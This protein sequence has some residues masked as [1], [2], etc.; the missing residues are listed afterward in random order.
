VRGTYTISTNTWDFGE[1]PDYSYKCSALYIPQTK[2]VLVVYG[3]DATN[4]MYD[5]V[6]D[7]YNT[8][9]TNLPNPGNT[10]AAGAVFYQD[11][12]WFAGAARDLQAFRSVS[13]DLSTWTNRTSNANGTAY[14]DLIQIDNVMITFGGIESDDELSEGV[15]RINL[16]NIT[17]EEWRTLDVELPMALGGATAQLVGPHIYLFGGVYHNETGYA[18]FNAKSWIVPCVNPAA[19]DQG[20]DV[21]TRQCMSPPV[22]PTEPVAPTNSPISAPKSATSNAAVKASF[23]GLVLAGICIAL[24]A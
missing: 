24:L 13:T 3:Y 9:F 18:L 19:C 5:P 12:L 17:S 16:Y 1:I 10:F 20:C 2:Q 8:S 21:E 14:M 7:T 6:T 15:A 22:A 23:G 11:S 4:W